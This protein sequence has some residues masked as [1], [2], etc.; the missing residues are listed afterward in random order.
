M[1]SKKKI[2][3]YL[4]SFP[5]YEDAI[6]NVMMPLLKSLQKDYQVDIFTKSTDGRALLDEDIDGFHVF[7]DKNYTKNEETRKK[8]FRI[9]YIRDTNPL[10]LDVNHQGLKKSVISLLNKINDASW[11]NH[12]NRKEAEPW[13]H[14]LKEI[15]SSDSYT[16]LIT[17]TSLIQTQTA[18][19]KLY[20]EGYFRSHGI[21]WIA[22]FTDPFSTYIRNLKHA[23]SKNFIQ[24]ETSIYQCADAVFVPPALYN[25]N[26][27]YPMKK[28]RDKTTA[29]EQAS[30]K[31]LADRG[32]HPDMNPA[33]YNCVYT[34]SLFDITVRNPD[35]FFKLTSKISP[36]IHFHIICNLTNSRVEELKKQYLDGHSNI[37]WYGR[38]SLDECF[39][40]ML[41]ADV[42]IN[43]GNECT[44]QTP[45]KVFDYIGAC[46][47]IVNF[48]S[49]DQDTSKKYL[50]RYPSK[51]NIKDKENE[52]PMDLQS[53]EQF[54]HN[55]K[56]ITVD[57]KKIMELYADCDSEL[58]GRT[59]LKKIHEILE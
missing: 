50:E 49:F 57:P 1:N 32:T 25:D 26:I 10:L 58:I 36:D 20:K 34:G 44:N 11:D 38:K 41:Q 9:S 47:P 14:T 46:R 17:V 52:D 7:R 43:L 3:V 19:M 51:L 29:L 33:H 55:S 21:K 28:Y 53:F 48:Y 39:D 54:I 4:G 24:F 30:F 31:L 59:F 35:Y 45:S 16:A 37:H 5:P 8:K 42:L 27:N 6:T 12:M 22:Y 18:A 23:N 15:L 13:R 2:L 40:Y 56:S